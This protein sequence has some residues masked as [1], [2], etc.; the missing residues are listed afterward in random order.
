MKPSRKRIYRPRAGISVPRVIRPV[1]Q[2]SLIESNTG[3][4]G[5]PLVAHSKFVA[6]DE[7]PF[8]YVMRT[9]NGA[10]IIAH[11]MTIQHALFLAG[12]EVIE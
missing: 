1:K 12:I 3:C 8:K 5:L 7:K 11:P 6:G 4:S 2:V 10:R 9:H